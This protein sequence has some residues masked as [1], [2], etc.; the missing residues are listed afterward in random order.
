ME[1]ENKAN[2]NDI[3]SYHENIETYTQNHLSTLQTNCCL[4][5]NFQKMYQ[6]TG[7]HLIH[8]TEHHKENQLQRPEIPC[9]IS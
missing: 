8:G 2:E 5:L 3:P 4:K 1:C 6:H 7:K 9:N